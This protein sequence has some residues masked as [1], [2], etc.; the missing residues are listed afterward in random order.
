MHP[1]ST[2]LIALQSP[3][4]GDGVTD[5][6]VKSWQRSLHQKAPGTRALYLNCVRWFEGWL[7]E[8]GRPDGAVGELL[9]V[10][11]RDA[12]AYFTDL[13]EHGIKP[14]TRRSRWI[15]LRSFYGW[16]LEEEEINVNP[17]A[18][19]KVERP[20]PAP[21]PVLSDTDLRALLKACEGKRFE[22]RRDYALLRLMAGTGLRRAEVA[23]LLLDDVDLDNRIA[24]VRKGKGGRARMVRFDAATAAAIDRYRRARAKHQYAPLP[25]LWLGKFGALTPKGIPDIL[26]RRAQ[27]AGINHVHA[28]R[29]RHTF[30]HRFLAGGGQE[31][32]LQKLGGWQNSDVM[33]RYGSARAV[34]RA[35]A[36]YDDVDPMAGL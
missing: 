21:I 12:E 16:L 26:E 2:A 17:L 29:L 20:D 9:E 5:E 22:D 31:G 8:N 18:K 34:D 23:S 4:V 13:E 28:H 24:A 30:A 1:C 15:A 7:R 11:R 6:L 10:G 27:Q 32:D 36:A 19:V 33:R 25:A 35:L 14:A 3:S